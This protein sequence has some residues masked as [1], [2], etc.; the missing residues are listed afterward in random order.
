MRML[1]YKR[2]GTPLFPDV[3]L[4]DTAS[5]LC[6]FIWKLPDIFVYL[7]SDKDF[8]KYQDSLC[9]C[10]ELKSLIAVQLQRIED[11]STQKNV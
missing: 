11:Y 10:H 7:L 4:K 9:I 1:K 8:I 6:Y 5:S 3:V 2:K